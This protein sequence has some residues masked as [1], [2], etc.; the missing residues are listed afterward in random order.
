MQLSVRSE[1]YIIINKKGNIATILLELFRDHIYYTVGHLG[2]METPKHPSA[3]R[4]ILRQQRKN[5]TKKNRNKSQQFVRELCPINQT[6]ISCYL[7]AK[8]LQSQK[9]SPH[10][11]SAYI[12]ST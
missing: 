6:N 2:P 1:Y 11:N 8:L 3:T 7:E 4:A 10:F 9:Q 5:K 12:A